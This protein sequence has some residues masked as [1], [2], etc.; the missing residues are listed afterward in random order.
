MYRNR[1]EEKI[2]GLGLLIVSLILWLFLLCN[3]LFWHIEITDKP[4]TNIEY[5]INK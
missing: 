4:D 5:L 2:K 1:N 3:Y